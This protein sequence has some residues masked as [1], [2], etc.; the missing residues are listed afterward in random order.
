MRVHKR[1]D[2]PER[3]NIAALFA[4]IG[5]SCEPRDPELHPLPGARARVLNHPWFHS[6]G[7]VAGAPTVMFN[8]DAGYASKEWTDEG[9][10]TLAR[11]ILQQTPW[12][13]L[14]N[15]PRPRPELGRALLAV[16]PNGNR[17][18]RLARGML[19]DFVAWMSL[20]RA[21]VTTDSGPQHLAH[22]LDVPS[23]TLYGPTDERRWGD[24]LRRPMHRTLRACTPDLTPD[25]KIGLPENHETGLIAPERVFEELQHL[26]TDSEV[27]AC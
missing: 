4:Q 27:E 6:V 7:P 20:C 5:L 1:W 19:E 26:M 21:I 11:L 14:V 16:D 13:I 2:L 9:W 10:I 12:R 18:G 15:E 23:V 17:V 24:P 22:A 3:D 8:P 25:E